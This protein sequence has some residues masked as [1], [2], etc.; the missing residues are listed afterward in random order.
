MKIN[1]LTRS[2][3]AMCLLGLVA[4]SA[5]AQSQGMLI[6]CGITM[7]RPIT[8]LARNFEKREPVKIEI[9]QGGSEDLY[10]S[11][12][13]AMH[14]DIYFPG[15]PSY[16]E[17]HK[18]E[19]LLGDYKVVGYNQLA[20]FVQKGNPKKVQPDL[21]ELMRKDLILTIG[22]AE[23]G[24]VGQET[25]Q[26]LDKFNMYP[27]VVKKAAFMMPDSRSLA[28]SLKRGDADATLSWRATAYFPDNAPY[29]DTV[30]LD[31]N[32]AVPQALLL[33]QLKFS[34]MPVLTRRFIDYVAS[35]EGQAVFRKF[36]FI[37]N[38]GKL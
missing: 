34:K 22:N 26:L 36:G 31:H 28:L 14:G 25:K 35:S 38:T 19:G 8:E 11:A 6:Y 9:A 12:K 15:E 29:M 37:D 18:A 20:I 32:M 1:A 16:L 7:V 33:I 4:A 10:Q 2:S 5:N 17:K 24:S 23:S 30:T 3:V 13:K 21:K 27:A